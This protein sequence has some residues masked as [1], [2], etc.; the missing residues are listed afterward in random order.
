MGSPGGFFFGARIPKNDSIPLLEMSLG[1]YLWSHSRNIDVTACGNFIKYS[2][3][4]HTEKDML[5]HL[6]YHTIG[7]D[8]IELVYHTKPPL[9]FVPQ[10]SFAKPQASFAKPSKPI[11]TLEK[12]KLTKLDGL[13]L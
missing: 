6:A 5:S 2:I 13:R 8:H 7:T 10:A 1:K 12:I 3:Y 9:V 11:F 4:L